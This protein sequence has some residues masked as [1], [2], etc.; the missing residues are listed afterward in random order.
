MPIS[1]GK[2]PQTGKPILM[3]GLMP[4]IWDGENV[5]K[6]LRVIKTNFPEYYRRVHYEMIVPAN[7]SKLELPDEIKEPDAK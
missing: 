5:L 6:L 4:E 2:H 7:G 3:V 1:S